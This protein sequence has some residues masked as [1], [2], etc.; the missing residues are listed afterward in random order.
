MGQRGS[1]CPDNADVIWH[2]EDLV[3]GDVSQLPKIRRAAVQSFL[4]YIIFADALGGFGI[5][6]TVI[7]ACFVRVKY[8]WHWM[9]VMDIM[10]TILKTLLEIVLRSKI[11]IFSSSQILRH[12]LDD[13]LLIFILLIIFVFPIYLYRGPYKNSRT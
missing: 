3:F 12:L 10:I 5:L 7:V 2:V 9:A 6:S 11:F 4:S 8:F 1:W 13:G